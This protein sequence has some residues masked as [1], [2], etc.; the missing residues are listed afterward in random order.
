MYRMQGGYLEIKNAVK[1]YNPKTSGEVSALNN[2]SLVI[3]QGEF[4]TIVGSN[5]AGK[6]TLF[7]IIAGSLRLDS[8]EVLLEG[9]S[10]AKISEHVRARYISRVRQNPNDSVILSM[11]IAENLSL[12]RLR[13]RKR[14]LKK[15]VKKEWK[16][17]F[18]EILKP[19]GIG[20]EK[21]LDDKS[22]LL[23]GGQKQALALIMATLTHPKLLLL[24]E[25]TAALDPKMSRKVLELT[26]RIVEENHVTTLM[27]THNINHA[28]DCGSRLMLLDQG[29]V[30][31]D[32][33]GNAK[34]QLTISDVIQKIEG[35]EIELEEDLQK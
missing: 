30:G 32:V 28:I 19:L 33:S 10:L 22:D 5:A 18:F 14:T 1:V 29:K 34:R 21:R 13:E 2:L 7:N 8:G 20:L 25:H 27:I 31:F 23:S 17:E 3:S 15:G 6:T 24:D 26:R 11:T 4:V 9:K 12:A 35:Q 16:K